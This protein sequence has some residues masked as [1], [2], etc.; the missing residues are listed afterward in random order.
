MQKFER[1]SQ[2]LFKQIEKGD[3]S[4]SGLPSE[5]L[6]AERLAANRLTVRKALNLLASKGI[7]HKLKK[8]GRYAILSNPSGS[9]QDLR[10]AF[11]VPP[12]FSSGNIRIW[13]KEILAYTAK[14]NIFFRPFLFVHWNDVSISD[15][16]ASFDGIF[17]VPAGEEIPK[18][19]LKKLQSTNGLV[20][21]NTDMS[22]SHILSIRLF[23][24]IFVQQTLDRLAQL[25]HKSIACL[26]IHNE[27]SDVLTDRIDQWNYWSVLNEN[28]A[29]LIK[30]DIN[31]Y[32][33][34]DVFLDSQIKSGR[35]KGSTAVFCTTIYAAIALIRACK[36]NGI[37]PEKDIAIYTVD[38]EGIGMHSTPSVSCFRRPDI[39]KML[40]PVF[41]WI[42]AGGN[43]QNW[44]G[45]LLLGPS[46]L[47]IYEGETS[48][49]P[50][51]TKNTT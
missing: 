31:A 42:R 7:V 19:T 22:H 29:P 23:P 5:R 46:K 38:D 12:E 28:D 18:D 10:I 4:L 49:S 34:G 32:D 40:D 44:K 9:T 25:D 43:T 51:K 37:D 45:P 39:Q 48:H 35:F 3:F 6:L 26:H 36:N 41:K 20:L 11:L 30:A 16:L 50:A 14:H 21:L 24:G 27:Q 47:E 8:N 17:I 1:I 2:T 13:H 15:I 33:E